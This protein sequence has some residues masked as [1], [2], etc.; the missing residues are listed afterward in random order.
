MIDVFALVFEF[1]LIIR[2]GGRRKQ[3]VI[4][5]SADQLPDILDFRDGALDVIVIVI[6]VGRDEKLSVPRG[7]FAQKPQETLVDQAFLAVPALRPGIGEIDMKDAD[8]F[9]GHRSGEEEPGLGFIELEVFE[10]P[11]AGAVDPELEKAYG[12]SSPVEASGKL[13]TLWAVIK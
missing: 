6:V 4:D 12:Q 8:T 11:A 13:I 1:D 3:P 5:A 10:F 7:F 9:I 2:F